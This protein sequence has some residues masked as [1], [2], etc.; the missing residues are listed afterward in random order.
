MADGHL[1]KCKTCVKS[2]VGKHRE[3]NLDTIRAYDRARGN[4]QGYGY[5]KGYR[6]SNPRK[7][8]AHNS[9]NN[10]IRDRRLIKG[11][12]EVCGATET[13][14]HHDDYSKPLDVRWLCAIHH[15]EW[16]TLNGE[17]ING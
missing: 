1:N 11:S 16:H 7:Y 8:K 5:V 2:R 12:C 14:G 6:E 13:H 9:V 4:R 15:N 17:A 10:A 3:A